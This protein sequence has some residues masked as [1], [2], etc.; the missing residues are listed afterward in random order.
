MPATVGSAARSRYTALT[1]QWLAEDLD[2]WT[3]RVVRRHFDPETGSPYWLA[4]A[5]DLPFDPR[6][7]TRYDELT[8]FG[9]FP[10]DVL[11]EA[12]PTGLVPRTV[13][14]PLAGRIWESGG[15]TGSPCRVFYTPEMIL[16]RGVW[17]RW[18]FVT[19]GFEPE[20]RWLHAT[21]T[22]PHLIG[23]GAWEISE[24]YASLVYGIDMDPRWVKRLIR[25]GRLKDAADYT[26]HLLE[27]ISTVLATQPVDY[28]N[29][30]P[31]LFAA[32]SRRHRDLAGRLAG[33]R[34]SGTQLSGDMYREFV[35]VLGG[36]PCGV[37]YGN[38]FG[39]AAS[40]P[41]ERDGDLLPYVPN[42]PQVTMAVVDKADWRRTVGYGEGG[43]VRLTVLH[44]DLFLPNVL[45]R[46]QAVRYDTGDGWPCDGVAN[47]RPLQIAQSAPEGLY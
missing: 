23:N 5:A 47:V 38:T 9:P 40:L 27:Q 30:T 25:A 21:P 41:A 29:T 7:I 19:E 14:R 43:Q 2:A 42:Y 17:R 31:A 37:S 39:N 8:S 10:L 20:R 35:A 28:L 16:H 13:P 26:D 46:D 32:L 18:S 45:E 34:L 44:D 11:R 12:D 6:D 24:L 4:R 1:E 33:V 15:T 3:A 22:G 36:G